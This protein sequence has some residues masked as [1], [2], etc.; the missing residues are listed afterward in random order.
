MQ[1]LPLKSALTPCLMF[2]ATAKRS[3]THSEGAVA[4][5]VSECWVKAAKLQRIAVRIHLQ[6]NALH[7]YNNDFI[8]FKFILNIANDSSDSNF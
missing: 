1:R 8:Y 6:D 5:K 3:P 7:K 2:Q 4:C